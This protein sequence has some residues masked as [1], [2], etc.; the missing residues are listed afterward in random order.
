MRILRRV[1]KEN[2]N[3]FLFG[4]QHIGCFTSHT[5][6]W[7]T[8]LHTMNSEYAGVKDNYGVDHGDC[9]EG[10]LIDDPRYDRITVKNHSVFK[11]MDQVVA[12]RSEIKHMMIT[13]LDGNHPDHLRRFGPISSEICDRLGID[14]G[15]WATTITYLD[16]RGEL[17]FKHFA[18]HGKRSINSTADDPKRRRVNMELTLKRL[19][20]HKMGDTALMSRGHSHKLI[21]CEPD[22]ELY[23]TSNKD[24]LKQKYTK[25]DPTA[26][27]IHPDS[28]WYVNAGSFLKLYGDD[29]SGYAEKAE[30]DPVE[31]G[32]AIVRIRNRVIEGIDPIVV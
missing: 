20:K 22:S 21:V 8:L 1:I 31:L 14:Y 12:D 16:E 30:Y 32:F 2:A 5:G 13:M 15:T 11:Q 23:I 7:E 25:I 26:D 19:L 10:I 24:S 6:G 28:K 27:Y 9:L 3:L 4:D 18:I 29:M 17:M